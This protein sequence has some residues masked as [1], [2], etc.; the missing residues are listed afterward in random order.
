MVIRKVALTLTEND[1][2]SGLQA[3]LEKAAA[4]QGEMVKKIKDPQILLDNG[5]LRFKCKASMGFIPMPVEAQ[6]RLEP[7][8]GGTA[9]A[10]TLT[11]VALAMMGGEA[12]AQAL[13][14]QL[15]TAIAGRPG[16]TVSGTTLTV[17]LKTLAEM[18]G[19]NLEGTLREITIHSG[20]LE[21][22]FS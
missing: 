3:A 13:M 17:E 2:N 21:L 19:I 1:I 18:R 8:A 16:L 7:T 11:K 6:V 12:A 5:V 15:A 20:A 4:V 22:D 9:L 10:I 14:G